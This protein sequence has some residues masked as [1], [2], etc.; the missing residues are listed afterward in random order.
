MGLLD[1]SVNLCSA[2]HLAGYPSVIGTLWTVLDEQSAN[3]AKQLYEL[4]YTDAQTLDI[5]RSA[6]S[7][8]TAIRILREKTTIVPNFRRKTPNN[9]TVWAPF[10]HVGV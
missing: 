4:M 7:L 9:P 3:V 2:I 5:K 1:E 8:H 6:V 10:I